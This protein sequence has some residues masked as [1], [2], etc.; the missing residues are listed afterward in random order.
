MPGSLL[1][2]MILSTLLCAS[3]AA[4]AWKQASTCYRLRK[5]VHELELSTADLNSTLENL[6]D[7]HKR[8]RSREGMK[9]LRARRS[10]QKTVETKAELLQRLGLAGKAGPDFARAQLSINANDSD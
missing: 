7:S 8:L 5:R 1:I 2:T 9:E 10:G 6:L 4:V 3:C